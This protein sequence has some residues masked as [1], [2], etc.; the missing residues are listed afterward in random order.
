MSEGIRGRALIINIREFRGADG[1][2]NHKYTRFGSEYD[3]D[4]LEKMF[5]GLG[6]DIVGNKDTTTNLT[7][8]VVL[9]LQEFVKMEISQNNPTL[10]TFYKRRLFIH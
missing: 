9:F 1:E 4:N 2:I 6:F 5:R 7:F 10:L 8:E 3:Y